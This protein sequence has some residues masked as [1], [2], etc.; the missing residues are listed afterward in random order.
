MM[1]DL[2][3]PERDGKGPGDDVG[4]GESESGRVC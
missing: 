1:T 3:I 2:D 4:R